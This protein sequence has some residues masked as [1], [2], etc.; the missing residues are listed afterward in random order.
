MEIYS[1]FNIDKYNFQ[2]LFVRDTAN[3]QITVCLFSEILKSNQGHSQVSQLQDPQFSIMQKL[4]PKR[5]K[6]FSP[7]LVE[8]QKINKFIFISN[9]NFSQFTRSKFVENSPHN[10]IQFF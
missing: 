5:F 9:T 10:F 4:K 7:H 1:N 2:S 6:V 8:C 3:W